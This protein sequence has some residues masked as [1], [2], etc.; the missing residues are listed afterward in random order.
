MTPSQRELFSLIVAKVIEH[1]QA[2][3]LFRLAAELGRDYRQAHDEL[4][5]L[6]RRKLVR[7]KR[8]APGSALIIRLTGEKERKL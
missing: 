4:T 1:G 5:Q 7:V 6:E 8:R 3:S 2:R